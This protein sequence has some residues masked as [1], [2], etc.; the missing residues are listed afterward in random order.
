MS[1]AYV[2]RF[3]LPY[4]GNPMKL[5]TVEI[6]AFLAKS[7]NTG[8]SAGVLKKFVEGVENNPLRLDGGLAAKL[9][10]VLSGC[11]LKTLSGLVEG[12]TLYS[13][14]QAIESIKN[15]GAISPL[16]IEELEELPLTAVLQSSDVY[17][18]LESG[19]LSEGLQALAKK[20][21]AKAAKA[22]KAAEKREAA[23]AAKENLD[24]IP[25]PSQDAPTPTYNP[26]AVIRQAVK[27]L[28]NE[29]LQALIVELATLSEL[30][31]AA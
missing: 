20:G 15:T 1:T 12:R 4:K 21:A 5:K 17:A 27:D 9:N 24:S 22:A 23:K 10:N 6:L 16:M 18:S 31:Q 28:D 30:R 11:T 2:I 8:L 29:G 13:I 19:V 7:Q 25:K 26:M 3:L 14:A